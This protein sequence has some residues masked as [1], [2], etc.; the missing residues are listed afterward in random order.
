[1]TGARPLRICVLTSVHPPKDARVFYRQARSTAAAGFDVLLIAPGAP[2]G[3]EDGV[4][5][6]SLPAWGG[7]AARPLR[8]PIV[9]WKAIRAKADV[10]HFHDPELLT[11]GVVLKWVTRKP[12]IYDSHE[13][14]REDIEGKQWIPPRLRHPVAVI[15]DRIEKWSAGRLS[16]VI[17][18]TDEMAAR[19]ER[20]QPRTI[21][22]KNLPVAPDAVVPPEARDNA[23]AYA[24]LMNVERGLDI[25]YETAR[26]VREKVPDA[27]FRILGNIEWEGM[28]E[29]ERN[30][31]AAEWEA[32][33]VRFLPSVPPG[34]VF[35]I[36]GRARI[37]WL[38][39]SPAFKN[40]LLAWP[41]K[42][43]EYMVVALPIVASD[44]PLQARVVREDDCG[45]VVEPL[46]PAAHAEA[47]ATLLVDPAEATRLGTNGRQAAL[48][49][50][51][52][53]GEARKLHTLYTALGAP[54]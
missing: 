43:V 26:L 11:W 23:V 48:Q 35:D 7:R 10:Y 20:F 49:K 52:W 32:S 37:G 29:R 24:G 47:I 22:V 42:L 4:R 18:V 41:N 25:L 40:N 45:V 9:F 27:E 19:F 36:I 6:A 44:L 13:Y 46:A 16:A 34:E 3:K 14:L 28:P 1:M 2:K 31:P 8:W 30:R 50:Y 5:F 12:V 17:A 39:R 51:T 53:Q 15:A 21:T 33:G 38:P 54:S